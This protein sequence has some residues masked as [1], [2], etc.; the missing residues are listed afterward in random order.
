VIHELGRR[1]Y[2]IAAIVFG[3]VA[4]R[5]NDPGTLPQ[6]QAITDPSIHAV[7]VYVVALAAIAGGLAVLWDR[8][9][10]TGAAVLATLFLVFA[11][12]R[13]PG[14]AGA[15]LVYDRWGNFFEQFSIFS[16][17]L[18]V[19]GSTLPNRSEWPHTT[20]TAGRIFLGMCAVS[21]ALEQTFYL[22]ATAVLVPPWM[23]GGQTFW[24]IAT[25][26]AFALAGIAIILNLRARAAASLLAVMIGLFA[27]MV[28]LPA[29]VS[30]PRSHVNW[31]EA[32]ET[33]A[34]AAAVWI[35]AAR[36]SYADRAQGRL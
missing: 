15:P 27:L 13:I 36:L 2:G 33:V 21:F 4:L 20:L 18:I 22:H 9:V 28:W 14:I 32:D 16:G 6:L 25:T 35:L 34:I 29:L 23:P 1:A 30:D 3:V 7:V 19:L 24:A 11:L 26:I 12:A 10:R 5:W 17:A 31:S 8:T